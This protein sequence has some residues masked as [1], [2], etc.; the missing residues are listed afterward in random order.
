MVTRDRT[1]E[2]GILR[3][4]GFRRGQIMGLV[5]GESL[6]LTLA[7]GVLGLVAAFCLLNLQDWY[8]GLRG[9]NMLIQVTPLVGALALAIA[10]LVGLFGGL[11]PAVLAGRL[12]IVSSLRNVD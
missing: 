8:Y 4:L 3:S 1:Q 10:G 7:G 5:L 6:V 12:N 2:F 11:I 9:I